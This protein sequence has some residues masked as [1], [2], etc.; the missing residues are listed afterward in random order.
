MMLKTVPSFGHKEIIDTLMINN[1]NISFSSFST[2]CCL[3]DWSGQ[4]ALEMIHYESTLHQQIAF[5]GQ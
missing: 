1:L 3:V 4:F 2:F 5:L